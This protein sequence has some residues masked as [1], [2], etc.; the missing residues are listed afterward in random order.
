MKLLNALEQ[1][2]FLFIYACD[3]VFF[4][5]VDVSNVNP[6]IKSDIN[7]PIEPREP[8]EESESCI[9]EA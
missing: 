5:I 7:L 2:L 8:M 9:I 6:Q 3:L 4:R 1:C